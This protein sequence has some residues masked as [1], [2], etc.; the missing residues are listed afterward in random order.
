VTQDGKREVLL[1]VPAYDFNWQTRYVLK[2]PR[3]LPAGSTLFCRAVFDN[4]KKNLANPDPTVTVTWG[5][6]SWDEMM[7]GYFDL[8]MPRDDERPA[9][10]KTVSTGL[11]IVGHFDAG[12][13]D[14]NAGLSK[15]EAAGHPVIS[16][17]FDRIDA[18]RD[19][20]LQLGEILTAVAKMRG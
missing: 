12:D 9:G 15:E 1:D 11:D 10:T 6:Q 13:K 20:L 16:A 4:S 18:D 3:T 14:G 5:D 19:G 7:L 17:A 8:L 2:E